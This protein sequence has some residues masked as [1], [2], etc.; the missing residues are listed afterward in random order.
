MSDEVFINIRVMVDDDELIDAK[1]PM[2]ITTRAYDRL[3]AA[4]ASAGYAVQ[5][6][7]KE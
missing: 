2:G 6:I 3:V 4:L 7:E 5:D 1:H